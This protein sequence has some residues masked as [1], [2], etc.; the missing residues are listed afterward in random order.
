MEPLK[1][2]IDNCSLNDVAPK[3]KNWEDTELGKYLLQKTQSGEIEV[4]ASP[5]SAIEIALNKDSVQRNN[6]AKALNTLINGQ[7]MMASKEF[8][9]VDD[10]L[11]LVEAT[12]INSTKT[13]RLEFLKANSSRIY[14]ALLGQLAALKDYDCSKGFIGVIAPKL[15]TQI[16]HSEILKS[17]KA[18]IEKRVNA[19]K[20]KTYS[21]LDYFNDLTDLSIE[22]L[23]FKQKEYE[24]QQFEID[25]NIIKTLHTYQDILIEGYS[26]DELSFSTDQVFVYWEDLSST[27]IDFQKIVS[28]WNERSPIEQSKGLSIKPLESEIIERFSQNRQSIKDYNI[29]LK[30]LVNR[31]YTQTIFTRVSNYIIIKDI[32]KGLHDGKIPSGG[33]ILDSSHCIASLYCDILLSRDKRLKASM[34]YW[35]KQVKMETGLFRETVKNIEELR[36]QIEKGLK[37]KNGH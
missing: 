5:A 14:I 28:N 33:I 37:H 9:I 10:F 6:M 2:Y 7:R 19:I 29:T 31:F 16:I 12:W 22:E 32:E 1:L 3:D 15:A 25:S 4:Y 11:R 18:E 20:N 8:Y 34:D 30:N 23:E 13:N 27:I 26:L 21:H 36:R 24:D 35:Y 17:P